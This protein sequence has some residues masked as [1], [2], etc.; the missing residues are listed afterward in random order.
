MGQRN[1]YLVFFY[2]NSESNGL[3]NNMGKGS[4]GMKRNTPVIRN[5]VIAKIGKCKYNLKG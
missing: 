5:I 1:M 2:I 4:L 3:W